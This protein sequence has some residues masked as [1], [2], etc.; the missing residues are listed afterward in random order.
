METIGPHI[1]TRP[2]RC[3]PSQAPCPTCREPGRRKAIH[4]RSV[5]TIAY[6][7]VVYLDVT[8]GEYRAR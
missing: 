8:Y 1:R 6:K 5:Q 4:H 3:S 7:Q 2:V